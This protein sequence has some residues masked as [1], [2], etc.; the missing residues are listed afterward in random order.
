MNESTLHRGVKSPPFKVFI[1][2]RLITVLL[3]NLNIDVE[4]ANDY[5]GYYL[6]RNISNER[7]KEMF[8]LDSLKLSFKKNTDQALLNLYLEKRHAYRYNK[9][10][11]LY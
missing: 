4:L 7:I 2:E 8:F 5:Q 3:E 1:L 10:N 11:H 6:K 9:F